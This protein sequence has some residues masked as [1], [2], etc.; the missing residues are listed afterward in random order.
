MTNGRRSLL[1]LNV[2]LAPHYMENY[3]QQQASYAYE[4]IGGNDVENIDVSIQQAGKMARP[5]A[6][7]CF[8]RQPKVTKYKIGW[9][10]KHGAA[11]F[12]VAKQSPGVLKTSGRSQLLK[13]CK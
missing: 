3:E 7:N 5:R 1:Q 2:V 8:L 12:T 11:Y 9:M 13:K 10:A 6:I 4:V